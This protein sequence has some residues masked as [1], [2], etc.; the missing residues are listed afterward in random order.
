MGIHEGRDRLYDTIEAEGRR[1]VE[2]VRHAAHP[3]AVAVGRWNE[4][5]LAD[6]LSIMGQMFADFARDDGPAAGDVTEIEAVYESLGQGQGADREMAEMADRLQTGLDA[7][8]A[9]ARDADPG[10]IITWHG[11]AKLTVPQLGGILIGEIFAHGL[12]MAGPEG[13]TWEVT[14]EQARWLIE[15]L[16]PVLPLFVDRPAAAGFSGSF[17]INLRG[18]P[19]LYLVFSDG[20]LSVQ[21]HAGSVDCRIKADPVDFVLVS[22]GRRSQWR[23][24]AR[25]KLMAY[26]RK[27]WLGL[28]LNSLLLNP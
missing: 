21:D 8:L 6:H 26:G 4:R 12:D 15:G 16:I 2:L 5:R 14:R 17:D 7:F 24:I 25:G 28:K 22:Y 11:G 13:T 27:P 23:S 9:T 19:R 10:R 18:G 20:E 3:E 1:L